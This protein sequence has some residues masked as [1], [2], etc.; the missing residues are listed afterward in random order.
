MYKLA[1]P[2]CTNSK[3]NNPENLDTMLQKYITL[4]AQTKWNFPV[5]F[6]VFVPEIDRFCW[7]CIDCRRLN[8]FTT[9]DTYPLPRRDNYLHSLCEATLFSTLDA[10]SEYWQ[11]PTAKEGCLC[12]NRKFIGFDACLVASLTHLTL[13]KFTQDNLLSQFNWQMYLIY[14]DSV[15]ELFNS[16]D[17]HSKNVDIVL[18]TLR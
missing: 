14:S 13:F 5:I 18:P 4:P 2:R 7:I 3:S 17:I 6:V 16:F 15:I 1:I 9:R 10:H 12:D 8:A 11:V